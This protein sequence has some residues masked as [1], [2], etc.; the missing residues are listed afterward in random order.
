M[1]SSFSSLHTEMR[2]CETASGSPAGQGRRVLLITYYWPPDASIGGVRPAK[3]A[4]QL[5]A[6]GWEPI[7]LTVKDQY[8]EEL[9]PSS[10]RLDSEF[11]TIRTRC[12]PTFP[13]IYLALRSCFR[14]FLPRPARQSSGPSV[15]EPTNEKANG[16]RRDSTLRHTLRSIMY[17]P[18]EYIGWLPFAVVHAWIVMRRY[19]IACVVSTGPPFTA[20]LAALCMKRLFRMPW[21]AEFRDPWASADTRP[22]E[23]MSQLSTWLNDRLERAVISRADRVVCV[24]PAT[25][26]WYRSLYSHLPSHHWET[27]TNGFTAQEFGTA[28][29]AP[30]PSKFTIS[31]LGTFD[32]ERSPEL[33]FRAVQELSREGIVNQDDL[34]I[35]FVGKCDAVRGRPMMDLVNA[36]GLNKVV[37]LAGTVPR[38]EALNEMRRSHVLLLLVTHQ[39][40]SVPAKTYEYLGAGR[41]ILA[42]TEKD[43]ATAEVLRRVGGAIISPDDIGEMKRVLRTWYHEYRCGDYKGLEHNEQFKLAAQEYE[44]GCLGRKYAALIESV[45]RP[46]F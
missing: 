33:L 27:I 30:D 14:R 22:A 12:L 5:R 18:D 39:K 36:Y 44:W 24:T 9:D 3:V 32:Y 37:T 31:Y 13:N 40:I 29:G 35:R 41:R 46:R 34:S 1:V 7:I 17:T 11:V 15:S 42:I 20:H 10:L 8:Y 21:I 23:I 4:T 25:T 26:G 2:H 19:D 43:G 38:H 6:N 28:T 16:P 45:V